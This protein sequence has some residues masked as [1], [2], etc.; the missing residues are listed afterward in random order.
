M[1]RRVPRDET[2]HV[3]KSHIRG[4]TVA[5]KNAVIGNKM[6]ISTITVDNDR[7]ILQKRVWNLAVLRGHNSRERKGSVVDT[8]THTH[9]C[10]VAESR[11]DI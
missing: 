2:N 5:G 6:Q 11:C 7:A 9:L 4:T 10:V 1:L 8:H 3:L